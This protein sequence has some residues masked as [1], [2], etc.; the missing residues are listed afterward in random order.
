[1]VELAPIS[2]AAASTLATRLTALVRGRKPGTPAHMSTAYDPASNQL[3][4]VFIAT[5]GGGS[6]FLSALDVM[7][8]DL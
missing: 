1:V 4:V 6:A 3:K 5:P 8:Q 2:D 7:A